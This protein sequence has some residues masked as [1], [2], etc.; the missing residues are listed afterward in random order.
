L[1]PVIKRGERADNVSEE[2]AEENCWIEYKKNKI[3]K[4]LGDKELLNCNVII[5]VKFR[6]T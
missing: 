3:L 5:M 2:G 4:K 1:I 6:D